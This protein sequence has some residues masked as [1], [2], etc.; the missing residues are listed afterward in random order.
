MKLASYIASMNHRTTAHTLSQH[1]SV[2]HAVR[3]EL[4]SRL[5]RSIMQVWQVHGYLPQQE[6][7][8]LFS[9]G[10]GGGGGEGEGGN[11]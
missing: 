2:Q 1:S 7:M 6:V 10:G 8:P 3:R 4:S 11:G 5:S 9:W